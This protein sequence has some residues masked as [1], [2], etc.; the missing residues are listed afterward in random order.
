[1]KNQ[2]I[3]KTINISLMLA[4]FMVWV[5][6]RPSLAAVTPTNLLSDPSF[7]D[8]NCASP[9]PN[10]VPCWQSFTNGNGTPTGFSYVPTTHTGSQGILFTN[11]STDNYGG[12]WQ[13][14]TLNQ[15]EAKPVF[16]G[17]YVKGDGIAMGEG[18]WLGASIYAEIHLTNGTV[19]YKNSV[20]NSGT[21]D[22]RWIGF[23][24]GNIYDPNTGAR[25]ITSPIAYIYVIPIMGNA[26]G[27]AYFDDIMISEFTPTT[28]AVT[29]MFDDGET[30]TYTEAKKLMDHYGYVGSTAVISD[31]TNEPGF[32]NPTQL[33]ALQTAGWEIVS[34][35]INHEDMTQMDPIAYDNELTGS[36]TAL[37]AQV[38]GLT[39]KDFAFPT[40]AYNMDL[41]AN[42]AKYYQSARA[43]ELGDNPIGLYPF[44][45]KVRS[46]VET[47]TLADVQ[48]WLDVA[49]AQ[50]RWEIL[51]MHT[52]DER[53][54]DTWHTSPA[55]LNHI[56]D[57]VQASALSVITYDQGI[58]NYAVA[59]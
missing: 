5:M 10:L 44:D 29:F 30:G 45:V 53:G 7:E 32:M 24:T 11:L 27:K 8:A 19:V 9:A 36:K 33:I 59:Q 47:T 18:T 20:S 50:S 12:A 41:N 57:A 35:S 37:E 6:P 48:S 56:L 40:G 46:V 21:F 22:W 1:M 49:K 42:A 39:I 14:V 4:M 13:L 31:N 3:A 2:I 55:E 34:H 51:V 23:N 52:I 43:Y 25:L 26:I 38:P 28:G 54:E 58:Q 17:A 16:I 15:T